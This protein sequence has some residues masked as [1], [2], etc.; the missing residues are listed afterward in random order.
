MKSKLEEQVVQKFSH[1]CPYCDQTII[2]DDLNLT[3]GENEVTCPSCKKKY[4]KIISDSPE[5]GRKGK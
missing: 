4:I 1:R 5:K 2:Y 3:S